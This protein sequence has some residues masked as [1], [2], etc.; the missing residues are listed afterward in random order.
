MS[1]SPVQLKKYSNLTARHRPNPT[2][3]GLRPAPMT[4]I[5]HHATRSHRGGRRGFRARHQPGPRLLHGR[6]TAMRSPSHP[7]GRGSDGLP[8]GPTRSSSEGSRDAVAG[9]R[10]YAELS[11][12]SYAA[13]GT[14]CGNHRANSLRH[15]GASQGMVS[16]GQ[17]HGIGAVSWTFLWAVFALQARGHW[18]EPSCA[19]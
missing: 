4:I 9:A 12:I 16:A 3:T 18:F 13:P 8:S 14:T 11:P 6:G 15:P 10:S 2:N 1:S 19:H 5:D 17:A 7:V